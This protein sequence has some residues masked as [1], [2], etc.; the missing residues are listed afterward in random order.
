MIG[1]DSKTPDGLV[2]ALDSKRRQ[3]GIDERALGLTVQWMIGHGLVDGTTHNTWQGGRATVWR[4][5]SLLPGA[6]DYVESVR[7]KQASK[8]TVVSGHNNVVVL[9]SNVANSFNTI[10]NT[11]LAE[12]INALRAQ[13]DAHRY[14]LDPDDLADLDQDLDV[15]EVELAKDRPRLDRIQLA[16][17]TFR[18]VEV[19]APWAEKIA[20]AFD[21]T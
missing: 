1:T 2:A 6:W 9:D 3:L 12:A 5:K 16:L 19:L 21:L 11:D 7:Q 10:A 13:L 4:I 18:G 8:T 14:A 17:A 20:K 15:I